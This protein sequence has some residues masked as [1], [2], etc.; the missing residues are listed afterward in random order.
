MTIDSR[1]YFGGLGP[2]DEQLPQG[3]T[4]SSTDGRQWSSVEGGAGFPG[5]LPPGGE[6]VYG[7]VA[8]RL[9]WGEPEMLD[10]P[11]PPPVPEGAEVLFDDAADG[12]PYYL[13][14]EGV[15][16]DILPPIPF[17]PPTGT[18][19]RSISGSP[20]AEVDLASIFGDRGPGAWTQSAFSSSIGLFVIVQTGG[21]T[22]AP[23]TLV[24][25]SVDGILWN[26]RDVNAAWLQPL[27]GED[28]V[29]FIGNRIV[30]DGPPVAT[31]T[32]FTRAD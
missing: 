2:T 7:D 32:L 16:V 5:S 6:A 3:W 14:D 28:S 27:M 25:H 26:V 30:P 1:V 11:G 4:W 13:D 29:L 10:E 31:T 20:W 24:G 23:T 18:L 15:R 9:T 8:L 12:L 17:G 22:N 21:E 19:E